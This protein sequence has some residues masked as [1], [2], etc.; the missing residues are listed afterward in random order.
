MDHKPGNKCRH[1]VKS[2]D[3]YQ[4]RNVKHDI[5]RGHI[6][7]WATN[8]TTETIVIITLH[9]NMGNNNSKIIENNGI[10]FNFEIRKRTIYCK[11]DRPISLTSHFGKIVVIMVNKRLK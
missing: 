11:L 3:L 5:R 2:S 7:L 6:K 1:D 8:Q 9:Q 10:G 4:R